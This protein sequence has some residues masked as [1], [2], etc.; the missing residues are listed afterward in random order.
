MLTNSCEGF[1]I[2]SFAA[3]VVE[4]AASIIRD[5][6]VAQTKIDPEAKTAVSM[7]SIPTY[8]PNAQGNGLAQGSAAA[9]NPDLVANAGSSRNPATYFQSSGLGGYSLAGPVYQKSDSKNGSGPPRAIL[10]PI[11]IITP[12]VHPAQT[13][14]AG[15]PLEQKNVNHNMPKRGQTAAKRPALEPPKLPA[16]KRRQTRGATPIQRAAAIVTENSETLNCIMVS[17]PPNTEKP[18]KAVSKDAVSAVPAT[19]SASPIKPDVHSPNNLTPEPNPED[20]P[21]AAPTQSADKSAVETKPVLNADGS[22][23]CPENAPSRFKVFKTRLSTCSKIH[24][25]Y[26]EDAPTMESF[27]NLVRNR[28]KLGEKQDIKGVEMII[29]DRVFVLNLRKEMDW[30]IALELAIEGGWRVDMVVEVGEAD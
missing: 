15:G 25:V 2:H 18:V 4:L 21:L 22:I 10:P 16:S 26:S 12:V 11:G 1:R 14:R 29:K 7:E 13:N 27:L 5:G 6:I 30:D 3:R 24:F 20:W 9:A 23:S 8:D 19:L 28:W 17:R